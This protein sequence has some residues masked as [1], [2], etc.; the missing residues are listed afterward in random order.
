[1]DLQDPSARLLLSHVVSLTDRFRFNQLGTENQALQAK[2][3]TGEFLDKVALRCPL[4][5][6]RSQL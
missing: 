1:M 5:F 3:I 6:L 4:E 2:P